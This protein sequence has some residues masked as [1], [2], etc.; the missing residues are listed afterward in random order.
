MFDVIIVGSG[1]SA[2]TSA[3]YLARSSKKVLMLE[4]EQI[5]GAIASSPRVENY[6][7]IKS[8]TGS[9]LA[10]N[11][12]EQI[13]N[14]GVEFK[15]EEAL[16]IKKNKDSFTVKTDTDSYKS[17]FVIIATGAKYR[18]LGLENEE[19]FVGNGE[20]FC[21]ACDGA[22]YN[23]KT[24]AVIGGGN[25]AIVNAIS[26]SENTKKLY[27]IQN[28]S[29]LTGEKSQ[30]EKLKKKD[31][32]EIIYDT[33]VTKLNGDD[34]LESIEIENKDGKKVLK[35]DG[36]F[37]SIGQL[38]NNDLAKDLIELDDYGYIKVDNNCKTSIDGIYAIGDIRSKKIRQLTTSTADGTIAAISI[39]NELDK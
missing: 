39:I 36:I 3:I 25:S 11:L 31:N 1:I 5:G 16:N 6:P 38:P 8:I 27:I 12:Y 20:S 7:G 17:K 10:S 22:F 37:V 29:K 13:E 2:M 28:I 34:E 33:V 14:F 21:V 9:N 24:V 18:R 4:C 23:N 30:V 19:D 26:L 35:V 32:V 15:F